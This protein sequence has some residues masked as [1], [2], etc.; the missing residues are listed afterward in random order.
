MS[1]VESCRAITAIAGA[2]FTAA[3]HKFAIWSSTARVASINTTAQGPVAGI[4][5]ENV[6]SGVAFPLIQ[7]DGGIAK[8]MAGAAITAGALIASNNAG[9]A[10]AFVD[11]SDN[12]AVG[13]AIEAAAADG[14]IIAI[15][16]YHVR[17]GVT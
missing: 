7:P 16:F 13:V 8:V 1:F 11:S 3:V 9:K 17:T 10:I 6:A 4:I 2:D 15:Q 5:G 14:D 12:V